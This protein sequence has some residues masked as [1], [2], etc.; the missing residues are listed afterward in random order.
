MLRTMA[1]MLH[2]DFILDDFIN[3]NRHCCVVNK[4]LGNVDKMWYVA[5]KHFR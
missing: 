5:E 1:T 2:I 3:V 4:N